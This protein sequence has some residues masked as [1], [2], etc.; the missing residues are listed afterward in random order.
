MCVEKDPQKCHR[1][2]IALDLERK[3]MK[4]IDI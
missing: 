1:H 3:R 4:S 2:R